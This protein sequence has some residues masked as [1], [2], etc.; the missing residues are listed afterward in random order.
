M[1]PKKQSLSA[2]QLLHIAGVGSFKIRQI[3]SAPDPCDIDGVVRARRASRAGAMAV[4]AAGPSDGGGEAAASAG[5]VLSAASDALQESLQAENEVAPQLYITSASIHSACIY[6]CLYACG[7]TRLC[8]C[9]CT[10][11]VHT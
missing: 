8:S 9:L 7:Y 4:D 11:P 1:Y 3:L 6:A 10:C 2:N 5:V